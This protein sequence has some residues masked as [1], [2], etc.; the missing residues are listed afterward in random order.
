MTWFAAGIDA[1]QSSTIA[2]IGDE[3]GRIVGRGCAG[4]ADEIGVAPASTRM[5]DALN[6][7][8]EAAR[9]AARL[10]PETTYA[11]IVAGVSGYDG[12]VYGVAP[13]LPT[14]RLTIVHDAPIAHAG[15]LGGAPGV[16]A[17]AGTGSVVYSVDAPASALTLGGWGYLFGDEGSAF[18]IARETLATLMRAHDERDSSYRSETRAACEFFGVP[19]LRRLAHAFY[20]GALTRDRLAAFAAHA[21]EFESFARLVERGADRLAALIGEAVAAGA[22]P[23]VALVGG[24][25]N[26]TRFRERVA[27]RV[28]E[29]VANVEIVVPRYEP[30]AGALLMAYRELG[31]EPERLYQ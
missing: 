17:I 12:R 3:N 14:Q 26:D 31:A 15:A 30:A 22:A 10:S 21:A 7:A 18:W 24:V 19:S 11:A 6:A 8:I 13:A 23:R 16:I 4:P 2:V 29:R 9:V 5:H 1:G 25:F 20:K 27:M 28:R